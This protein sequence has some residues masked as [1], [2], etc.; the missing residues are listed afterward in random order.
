M[1]YDEK[2][3]EQMITVIKNLK[4]ERQDNIK[5]NSSNNINIP[6]NQTFNMNNRKNNNNNSI[7]KNIENKNTNFYS[8]I[9]SGEKTIADDKDSNISM[10]NSFDSS[11]QIQK[12]DP[13]SLNINSAVLPNKEVVFEKIEK[14]TILERQN[15]E[16]LV[17]D[18]LLNT[19][20]NKDFMKEVVTTI[21]KEFNDANIQQHIV[22]EIRS[23]TEKLIEEKTNNMIKEILQEI[24]K[25]LINK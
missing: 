22:N 23:Q 14:D 17:R 7:L 20:E 3:L 25:V 11:S 4:Q 18:I 2:E 12:K 10:S 5:N 8:R 1:A 19:I 15:L 21:I 24:G 13:F 6:N 16:I 9:F